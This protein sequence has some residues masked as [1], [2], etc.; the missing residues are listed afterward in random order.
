[1][2]ES[3]QHNLEL[4]HSIRPTVVVTNITVRLS[5]KFEGKNSEVTAV[6]V[7]HGLSII[8]CCGS[9]LTQGASR[10]HFNART[11]FTSR[12]GHS[13]QHALAKNCSSTPSL[14][15]FLVVLPFRS[16]NTLPRHQDAG[17]QASQLSSTSRLQLH[18][19]AL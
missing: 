3:A 6:R 19:G 5:L 17:K 1:M 18:Q 13:G 4:F 8:T 9:H 7:Q 14:N 15:N 11:H 12:K 16:S 2:R 10:V